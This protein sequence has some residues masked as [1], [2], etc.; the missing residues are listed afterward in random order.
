MHRNK[1]IT[2]V[3]NRQNFDANLKNSFEIPFSHPHISSILLFVQAKQTGWTPQLLTRGFNADGNFI[4]HDS[5]IFSVDFH[6]YNVVFELEAWAIY[7]H[8]LHSVSRECDNRPTSQPTSVPPKTPRITFNNPSRIEAVIRSSFVF[9]QITSPRVPPH[10]SGTTGWS[11]RCQWQF[12][13]SRC[14]SRAAVVLFGCNFSVELACCLF[15]SLHLK[16]DGRRFV[17][18]S[19]PDLTPKQWIRE[20][21]EREGF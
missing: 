18:A 2:W 8:T 1:N 7:S 13:T 15:V 17:L 3:K 19:S 4:R 14:N 10:T 9:P 5:L 16:T 21:N 6:Q 11:G 20:E 12:F